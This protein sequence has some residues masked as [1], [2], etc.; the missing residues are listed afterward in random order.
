MINVLDKV[1]K[2]FNGVIQA[3]VAKQVVINQ[4]ATNNQPMISNPLGT[5]RGIEIAGV[6]RA[7]H[8][9]FILGSPVDDKPSGAGPVAAGTK[10]TGVALYISATRSL[11]SAIYPLA[12]S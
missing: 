10:I 3:E 11:H 1:A 5:G 2:W 7:V 6:P 4:Q 8:G 9:A 12:S